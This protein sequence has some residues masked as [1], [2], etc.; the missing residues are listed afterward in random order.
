MPKDLAA[1]DSTP[2]A[3]KHCVPCEGDVAPFTEAQAADSVRAVPSWNLSPD[4]TGISRTWKFSSF[5]AAMAFVNQVA[6]IAESEDHHPDIHVSYR[7]VRLDLTTHAIHGL[8]ENDFILAA[9]I[10]AQER[11]GG[12]RPSGTLAEEGGEH[13][14]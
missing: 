10:D 3:L 1:K 7:R 9:K 11:S 6:D 12:R 4:A 13:M 2:L 14:Q 5:R 8:S